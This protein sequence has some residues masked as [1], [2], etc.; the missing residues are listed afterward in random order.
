MI[1]LEN[2]DKRYGKESVQV[3]KMNHESGPG[4]LAD[5]MASLLNIP[6]D[7]KRRL[8]EADISRHV[9]QCSEL[10]LRHLIAEPQPDLTNLS[11]QACLNHLEHCVSLP[12]LSRTN[13][14]DPGQRRSRAAIPLAAA[15]GIDP[16]RGIRKEDRRFLFNG[17]RLPRQERSK[18]IG[19]I[20]RVFSF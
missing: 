3:L 5:L 17:L 12:N 7:D 11:E 1:R 19:L 16:C 20:S 10:L 4:F 14:N 18:T 13:N 2:V 15:G 8:V 6:L 9:N